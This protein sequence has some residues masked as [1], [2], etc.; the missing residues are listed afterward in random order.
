M[1]T[2]EL[3][4]AFHVLASSPNYTTFELKSNKLKVT[5]VPA[6]SAFNTIHSQIVYHV[7][8]AEEGVGYTGSTHLLEHLMFK[9]KNPKYKDIFSALEPAGATI[10]AR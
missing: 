4:D 5:V 10:N 1:N 8:S 3:N 9:S 2:Q 7:G 6:T